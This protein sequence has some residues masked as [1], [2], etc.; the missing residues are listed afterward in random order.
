[1]ASHRKSI[2]TL[3][4]G[5][6]GDK[7]ILFVQGILLV[8]LYLSEL[9]VDVYGYWLATG[10]VIAWL[11]AFDMRMAIVINQKISSAYGAGRTSD[12]NTAFVSG[13]FVYCLILLPVLPIAMIGFPYLAQ[14]LKLPDELYQDFHQA[15]FFATLGLVLSFL[16]GGL[17]SLSKGILRPRF[18]VIVHFI[19]G[20]IQIICIA[21]LLYDGWGVRAIGFALFL[22]FALS[23]ILNASYAFF[24]LLEIN[25][26][27]QSMYPSLGLMRDYFSILPPMFVSRLTTGVVSK[28]EPTMVLKFLGPEAAAGYAVTKA[29]GAIL[30]GLANSVTA[31]VFPSFATICGE[32]SQQ[33]TVKAFIR[34]LGIVSGFSLFYFGSYILLN[35]SFVLLWVGED[36]FKGNVLSLLIGI[37]FSGVVLSNYLNNTLTA[38]GDFNFAS[39]LRTLEETIRFIL[40]IVFLS[41]FGLN[42][43]PVAVIVTT[44]GGCFFYWHRIGIRLELMVLS[45][46]TL[47]NLLLGVL[48]AFPLCGVISGHIHVSSWFGF[49]LIAVIV[50]LSLIGLSS[51]LMPSFRSEIL[52]ILSLGIKLIRKMGK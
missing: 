18:P 44:V 30:V 8:P 39:W 40:I 51:L 13:M 41:L 23:A 4:V 14:F 26:D 47:R 20:L 12:V 50:S 52:R 22:R 24:L 2:V 3:L 19:C 10:G 28:I 36:L 7:F 6:V 1:M 34:C 38:M 35:H 5:G 27:R 48:L 31:S 49:S 11:G 29:A 42:G 45:R 25:T 17:G 46:D 32:A 15:Y 9:G 21:V 33:N 16:A 43:M 37:S